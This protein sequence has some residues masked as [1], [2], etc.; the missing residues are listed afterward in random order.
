MSALRP[1]DVEAAFVSLLSP[2]GVH[3]STRI[4]NPRP[5]SHVKVTRAGGNRVNL[6][7]ERPL[8]VLECWAGTSVEAFDLA[9]R[10]W[11]VLDG[12]SGS[13][14]NGIALDFPTNSLA[15]PISM[16]DP[17]TSSPRYQ[18]TCQPFARLLEGV[19]P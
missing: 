10:A 12:A 11:Q 19:T 14:V 3:V 13:V 15:S 5:V 6:V 17:D 2:L 4:P 1:G 9:A 8:L 16:P 7:I 18:F